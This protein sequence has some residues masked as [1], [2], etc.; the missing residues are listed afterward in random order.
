MIATYHFLPYNK[1]SVLTITQII[2]VPSV[3]PTTN[4]RSSNVIFMHVIESEKN[5]FPKQQI[6]KCSKVIKEMVDK[7]Y[8]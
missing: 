4:N 1:P 5:L 6:V 7:I 8:L 3:E 2:K